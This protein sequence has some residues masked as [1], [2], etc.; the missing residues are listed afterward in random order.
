[1]ETLVELKFLDSS[2]SSSNCSVRVFRAYPLVEI[3]QEVPCRAIRGKS[4]NSR[5]QYLGQQHPPPLL[6]AVLEAQKDLAAQAGSECLLISDVWG[7]C[8]QFSC[9]NCVVKSAVSGV[10]LTVGFSPHNAF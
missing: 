10:V 1:M 8:L 4:S 2:F 3:C 7:G 6:Q 9:D 5:Q